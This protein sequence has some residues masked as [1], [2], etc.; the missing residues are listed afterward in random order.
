MTGMLNAVATTSS[1]DD[2]PSAVKYAGVGYDGGM[3]ITESGV[4]ESGVTE[5]GVTESGVTESGVAP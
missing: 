3:S 2:D 5:S 4:T 1:S